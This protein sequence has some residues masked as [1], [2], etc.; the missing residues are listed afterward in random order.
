MDEN[1]REL[2]PEDLERVSGGSVQNDRDF[3]EPLPVEDDPLR[4]QVGP[5]DRSC[6]GNKSTRRKKKPEAARK[7]K[8]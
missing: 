4:G 1:K 5:G 6:A 8:W 7:R 2:N 3:L